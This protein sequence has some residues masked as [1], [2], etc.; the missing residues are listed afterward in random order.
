VKCYADTSFLLALYREQTA[1]RVANA[2]MQR[3]VAPLPLTPLVFLELRNGLNLALFRREIDTGVRNAAWAQIERDIRD[4]VLA[5]VVPSAA[6]VYD[7]AAALSDQH[8]PSL[9]TRTLD[10]L[11]VAAALVLGTGRLLSLDQRQR[12]LAEKVGLAVA[13]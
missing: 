2:I 10:V 7:Q 13:P 11:H 3:V 12:A 8:G 1:S 5:H 4:G 9:G 6:A